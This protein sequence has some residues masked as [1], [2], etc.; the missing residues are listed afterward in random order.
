VVCSRDESPRIAEQVLAWLNDPE[1]AHQLSLR[2]EQL[3]ARVAQPG[4]CQRAAQFLV[5][6]ITSRRA[7]A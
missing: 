7:V 3:R 4:A 6:A 5:Q 2:L 1:S